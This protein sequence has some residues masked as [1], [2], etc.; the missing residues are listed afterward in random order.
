MGV[1]ITWTVYLVFYALNLGLCTLRIV[2]LYLDMLFN[3]F[4]QTSVE[5]LTGKDEP[6]PS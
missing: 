3:F 6:Y 2:V 5:A 1:K 4:L